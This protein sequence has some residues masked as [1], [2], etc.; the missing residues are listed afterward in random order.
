MPPSVEWVAVMLTL[1]KFAHVFVV[2]VL[3]VVAYR[4]SKR[5]SESSGPPPPKH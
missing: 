3:L 5:Y 1:A 4:W 2:G